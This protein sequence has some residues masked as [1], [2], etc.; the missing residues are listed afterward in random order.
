MA[1]E[2]GGHNVEMRLQCTS[3][4]IPTTAVV[5]AAMDEDQRRRRLITPVGIM[6]PQ[7]LRFVE[8][9]FRVGR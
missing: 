7:T 2:I 1:T 8:T 5:A 9:I 4:R 3:D 6:Q